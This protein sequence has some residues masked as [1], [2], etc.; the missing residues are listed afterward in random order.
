MLWQPCLSV[1]QRRASIRKS[2]GRSF[3]YYWAHQKQ[4]L[5]WCPDVGSQIAF[6]CHAYLLRSTMSMSDIAPP[7]C[8]PQPTPAIEIAAGADQESS[9]L[10]TTKPVPKTPL[11]PMPTCLWQNCQITKAELS[12]KSRQWLTLYKPSEVWICHVASVLEHGLYPAM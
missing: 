8:K 10:P 11:Q 9:F 4:A 7:N 3:F 12:S 1:I 5:Q 2:V 6:V